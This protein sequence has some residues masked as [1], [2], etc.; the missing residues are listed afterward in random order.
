MLSAVLGLD[1]L[2]DADEALTLFWKHRHHL[3][4]LSEDV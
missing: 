4:E 3:D 2:E 1:L